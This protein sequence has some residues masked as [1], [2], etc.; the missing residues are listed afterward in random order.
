MRLEKVSETQFKY[1][2]EVDGNL[3]VSETMTN[4]KAEYGSAVF[5]KKIAEYEWLPKKGMR[6]GFYLNRPS[7]RRCIEWEI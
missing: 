5:P 4:Y 2:L 7:P 6:F 3:Y 1:N